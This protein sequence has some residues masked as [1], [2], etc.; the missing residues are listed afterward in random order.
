[1]IKCHFFK[2]GK[3]CVLPIHFLHVQGILTCP[4][5]VFETIVFMTL[6]IYFA[7]YFCLKFFLKWLVSFSTNQTR[8][9]KQ[10]IQYCCIQYQVAIIRFI[11]V[12][13]CI[14]LLRVLHSPQSSLQYPHS[15]SKRSV[16]LNSSSKHYAQSS[17]R[18]RS[19][20]V[21]SVHSQIRTVHW[22]LA[23][24]RASCNPSTFSKI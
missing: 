4:T 12:A 9:K 20:L 7:Y 3:I 24:I 10:K 11:I 6:D 13:F 14:K 5:T 17:S 1:M 19:Q 2:G 22:K 23:N 18:S 16:T 15:A 21:S 8:N